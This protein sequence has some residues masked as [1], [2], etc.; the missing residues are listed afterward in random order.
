MVTPLSA[1]SA[2]LLLAAADC[3]LLV[4]TKFLEVSAA[5]LLAVFGFDAGTATAGLDG[6]AAGAGFAAGLTTL[7][8]GFAFAAGAAFFTGTT[9]FTAAF[10]TGLAAGLRAGADFAAGL[11]AFFGAAAFAFAT[12]LAGTLRDAAA[13]ARAAGFAGLV[14]LRGR[15][16]ERRV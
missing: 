8:A 10:A 3:G 15:S 6:L 13:P 7:G 16:E 12:G 5:W 1:G 4:V 2:F 9:F 14:L 11:A